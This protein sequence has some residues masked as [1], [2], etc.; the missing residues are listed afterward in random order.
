[1]RCP[2][3]ALGFLRTVYA[4]FGYTGCFALPT[5]EFLDVLPRV[6]HETNSASQG[7]HWVRP[8]ISRE[9]PT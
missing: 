1:M 9:R 7:A 3:D 6:T 2:R 8:L 5:T 4:G